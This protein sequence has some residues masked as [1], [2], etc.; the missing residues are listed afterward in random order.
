M[1]ISSSTLRMT[2]SRRLSASRK[3]FRMPGRITGCDPVQTDFGVAVSIAVT[4]CEYCTHCAICALRWARPAAV[5][6]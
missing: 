6:L 2:M 4:V 5:I 3:N 1:W